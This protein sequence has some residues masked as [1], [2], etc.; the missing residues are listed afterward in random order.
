VGTD[1]L[2]DGTIVHVPAVDKVK[3]PSTAKSQV[4]FPLTDGE[5]LI[6]DI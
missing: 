5:I 1:R 4:D 6:V 3:G 2:V